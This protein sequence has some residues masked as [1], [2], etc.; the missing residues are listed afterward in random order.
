MVIF[1]MEKLREYD[2]EG[3]E[4]FEKMQEDEEELD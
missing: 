1:D 4:N 3:V 2:P